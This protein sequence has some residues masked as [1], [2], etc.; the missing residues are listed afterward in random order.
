MRLLL[1]EVFFLLL[2][3]AGVALVY[4]PAGLIVLGALG[5]LACE[6]A[7]SRR[8]GGVER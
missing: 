2:L 1:V 4:A 8:P 3:A 7:G 6:R 5:A